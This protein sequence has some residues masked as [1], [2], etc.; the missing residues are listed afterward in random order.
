MWRVERGN[1]IPA[2][3]YKRIQPQRVEFLEGQTARTLFIP[4]LAHS[5]SHVPRGP[6]FFDVVLQP[7]AGGPALG[8][9]PRITVVIDPMPSPSV[10]V[11]TSEPGS[12]AFP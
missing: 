12:S 1:A 8:R 7:V 9:L 4:L 6:R 5:T 11:A 10:W 3:D 2:V